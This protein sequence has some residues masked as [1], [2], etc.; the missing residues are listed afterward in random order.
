MVGLS[1]GESDGRGANACD[2][3]STARRRRSRKRYEAVKERFDT[4]DMYMTKPETVARV[5]G[6]ESKGSICVR[7]R[8]PH[9]YDVRRMLPPS[10]GQRH[11]KCHIRNAG[12]GEKP[13]IMEGEWGRVA[14]SWFQLPI[15]DQ[16]CCVP[17]WCK[18]MP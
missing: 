2:I 1:D 11:V 8:L 12:D 13:K 5:A 7:W 15:R 6:L 4:G 3:E 18:R 14:D 10:A 9:G 17:V 16:C